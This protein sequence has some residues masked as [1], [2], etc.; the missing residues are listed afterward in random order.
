MDIAVNLVENYLRLNGYLT[1]SEFEV[2][3]R[4][5]DGR[6]EAVTDVDIMGLRMPGD[7]YAGDP[8]GDDDCE[9]LLIDDPV[10]DL[11]DDLADVIVGEVK[12]GTAELNDGIR[13]HE[14]LHSMLRRVEWLYAEPLSAVISALQH[15]GLHTSPARGGG[16]IRTRLVAFGQSDVS[17]LHTISHAHM[18]STMVRFFDELEDAFRPVQFRDP[19]PALLSLLHKSG[20]DVSEA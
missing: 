17:D 10:L 18:L 5:E 2:T 14:A 9:M 6:F 15:H 20:F 13:S 12:Q 4:R 19:A 3:R 7:V 16:E 8:H 11:R 1:L